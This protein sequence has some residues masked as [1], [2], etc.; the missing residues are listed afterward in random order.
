MTFDASALNDICT[1]KIVAATA[2]FA[3]TI[4]I[5]VFGVTA[6]RASSAAFAVVIAFFGIT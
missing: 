1:D 3:F 4:D 5:E 2:P 6:S